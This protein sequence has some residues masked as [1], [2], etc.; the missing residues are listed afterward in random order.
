LQPVAAA[1][2]KQQQMDFHPHYPGFQGTVV[3]Y[4]K[5]EV[6]AQC[7]RVELLDDLDEPGA[8]GYHTDDANQPYAVVDATLSSGQKDDAWTVTASHEIMEMLADPWGNRLHGA[9][10]PAGAEHAYRTF[11]LKKPTEDVHYLLEV[12]DPP[13]AESYLVDGVSVSDFVLPDWYRTNPKVGLFYSFTGYCTKPRQVAP[14]G[15]VSFMGG[16][17]RWYQ[18]FCDNSGRLTYQRLGVFSKQFHTSSLREFTDAHARGA[19]SHN[20][21]LEPLEGE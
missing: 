19:R 5:D 2:N 4:P 16:G 13:E 20:H 17:R 7:W 6:P 10:L 11:G 3:P 12:A 9:N 8:L 18:I 21:Q 1:L 14:G 15:Y